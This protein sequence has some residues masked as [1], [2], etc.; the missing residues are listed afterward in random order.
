MFEVN[1]E[2]WSVRRPQLTCAAWTSWP[3]VASGCG[4]RGE[5]ED[6][7]RLG[8]VRW[9]VEALCGRGERPP[10]QPLKGSIG[11]A[12]IEAVRVERRAYP[13]ESLV[14]F[15]MRRVGQDRLELLIAPWAADILRGTRPCPDTQRG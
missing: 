3:S 10:G 2:R 8:R 5:I 6:S 1:Q 9:V 11:V 13:G 14:V 4:S 7:T 15:G 12:E